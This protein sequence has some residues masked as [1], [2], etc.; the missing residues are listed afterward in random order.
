MP[1]NAI[2]MILNKYVNTLESEERNKFVAELN[3]YAEDD[4]VP[5]FVQDNIKEFIVDYLSPVDE[6]G[7][8]DQKL[9]IERSA[10]FEN[11][12][13]VSNPNID[14]V[15]KEKEK[16]AQVV[17]KKAKEADRESRQRENTNLSSQPSVHE[18]K[19]EQVSRSASNQFEEQKEEKSAKQRAEEELLKKRNTGSYDVSTH[20]E[21]S[22]NK[23]SK[24]ILERLMEWLNL[25]LEKE[26]LGKNQIQNI[27]NFMDGLDQTGKNERGKNST[28]FKLKVLRDDAVVNNN[29]AEF[30]RY[31]DEAMTKFEELC[32]SEN[33][34]I[35]D[36]QFKHA[37]AAKKKL[38]EFFD[39]C[40]EYK[41]GNYVFKGGNL[42]EITEKAKTTCAVLKDYLDNRKPNLREKIFRTSKLKRYPAIDDIYIALE[43]MLVLDLNIPVDW[44]S[45]SLNANSKLMYD[46]SDEERYNRWLASEN[47]KE[48]EKRSPRIK[49]AQ[50]KK[51][52][53]TKK[54]KKQLV[55]RFKKALNTYSDDPE[56]K[57]GKKTEEK[58]EEENKMENIQK[59]DTWE[60]LTQDEIK[61]IRKDNAEKEFYEGYE[62]FLNIQTDSYKKQNALKLVNSNDPEVLEQWLEKKINNKSDDAEVSKLQN[63]VNYRIDKLKEVNEVIKNAEKNMQ[64]HE[65]GQFQ[66]I[67]EGN[68]SK[69]YKVANV[70]QSEIQTTSNGCWSVALS[71]MLE[72]RGVKLDQSQ[73]RAYR[74]DVD[75]FPNDIGVAN[76]DK[77]NSIHA[78]T[79][80]IQ[81]V[82][83]NTAVNSASYFRCPNPEKPL[84]E[85][86]KEQELKKV[87]T[88]MNEVIQHAMEKGKGPVALLVGNHYR[89]IYEL[90]DNNGDVTVKFC[91]PEESKPQEMKLEELAEKAY[92]FNEK[93]NEDKNGTVLSEERYCFAVQWLEDLKNGKGEVELDEELKEKIEYGQ[94]GKLSLKDG[95]KSMDESWCHVCIENKKISSDCSHSTYLPQKLIDIQ[96]N[97]EKTTDS[98]KLVKF[99]ELKV[100]KNDSIEII[101]ANKKKSIFQKT[102]QTEL[103]I[104]RAEPPHTK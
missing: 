71:T 31:L 94:D 37:S 38:K 66:T 99:S 9:A 42:G 29:K 52:K 104:P 17:E 86:Q 30:K 53:V 97:K 73:I 103:Q 43:K 28:K 40:Y 68:G 60:G 69:T 90:K 80:L 36:E 82:L 93:I 76:Q 10:A 87:A 47:E 101:S 8:L 67:D 83:P 34:N 84:T 59:K 26:E 63:Y 48:Q 4:N 88:T 92:T 91:D 102:K 22:Q 85:A 44:N 54:S 1:E 50:V 74:P 72:H 81:S 89:T 6:K 57:E 58:I 39:T 95:A 18:K 5:S 70:N 16:K 23:T 100:S 14:K 55:E 45:Y 20:H 13:T 62:K 51:G 61:K 77:P 19:N 15:K 96:K 25:N 46:G 2:C 79:D 7:N 27:F 32:D 41:D 49:N 65:V 24:S 12:T 21:S 75:N 98:R 64:N 3:Q 35:S 33:D 11:L 78:Y 56:E